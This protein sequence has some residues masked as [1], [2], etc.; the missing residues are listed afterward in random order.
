[1]D[2]NTT[3]QIAKIGIDIAEH[4]VEKVSQKAEDVGTIVKFDNTNTTMYPGDYIN[5]PNN[6]YS[7]VFQNDGNL[8]YY[9][10]SASGDSRDPV[11]EAGIHGQGATRVV[12]QHDGNLVAYKGE[13]TVLWA[14]Y[15][16]LVIDNPDDETAQ[17][18]TPEEVLDQTHHW[19]GKLFVICNDGKWGI[20][21]KDTFN[22]KDKIFSDPMYPKG[23]K[24]G[25]FTDKSWWFTLQGKLTLIGIEI[26]AVASVVG[27]E[28][29][30]GGAAEAGGGEI[31][32]DFLGTKAQWRAAYA[33]MEAA[34]TSADP[35]AAGYD[36]KLFRFRLWQD[37]VRAGVCK[38]VML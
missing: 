23:K 3:I 31:T 34:A 16:W 35:A 1:M 7:L 24:G 27:L 13:K 37:S 17:Y 29:I 2:S 36:Y 25:K 26:L 22:D 14:S 30:C 11:W 33:E 4:V 38:N 5:S 6:R 9:K 19:V 28:A 32:A 20:I 21:C 15:T 18:G 8:V 10:N 12:F